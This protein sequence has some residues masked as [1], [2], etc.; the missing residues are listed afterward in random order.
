LGAKCKFFICSD[1]GIA[2]VPEVFR[3]P[4]VYTNW[5]PLKR[6]S[7]WALNGLF[8]CK[9][10]YSHKKKRLLLFREIIHS[11]LGEFGAKNAFIQEEVELIESTPE[12]IAAAAIEMDE[13]LKGTWKTTKEDEELQRRFWALFGS[14]KLKSPQVR[15]GAEFLRENQELLS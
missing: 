3:R 11:P 5:T 7:P 15:M 14:H 2:I 1:A 4:V 6:I 12:E 8:I 10:F 13:R 9:K